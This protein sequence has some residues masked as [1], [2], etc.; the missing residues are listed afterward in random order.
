MPKSVTI[1]FSKYKDNITEDLYETLALPNNLNS[2]YNLQ[3][4][5]KDKNI[6]HIVNLVN[7][8]TKRYYCNF[9][10]S[11]QIYYGVSV[12]RHKK[13][14]FFE[15]QSKLKVISEYVNSISISAP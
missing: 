9:K 14:R 4:N 10:I 3:N 1:Q 15:I 6:T 11:N 13:A 12:F 8:A 5:S 2:A 7:K